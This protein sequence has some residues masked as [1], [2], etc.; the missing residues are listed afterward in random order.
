MV[1]HIQFI[2]VH[3]HIVKLPPYSPFLNDIELV[4]N[5]VKQ[6]LEKNHFTKTNPYIST[7]LVVEHLRNTNL[8]PALESAGCAVIKA[9][10][11]VTILI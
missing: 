10:I 11:P 6:L 5:M 3:D 9:I 1:A 4:F 7:I 8:G 2:G